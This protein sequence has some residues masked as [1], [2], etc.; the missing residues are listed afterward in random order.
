MPHTARAICNTGFQEDNTQVKIWAKSPCCK[1]FRVSCKWSYFAY[2]GQIRAGEGPNTTTAVAFLGV[3]LGEYIAAIKSATKGPDGVWTAA[4]VHE[5][6]RTKTVE[7]GNEWTLLFDGYP[8]ITAG[9][10]ER[11]TGRWMGAAFKEKLAASCVLQ[12]V[13]S[14]D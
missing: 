4:L 2:V 5:G 10:R 3:V 11:E 7:I 14:C 9:S 8:A 12:E 6:T 13:G 1:K